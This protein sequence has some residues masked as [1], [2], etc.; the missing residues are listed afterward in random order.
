[1]TIRSTYQGSRPML[2]IA[3]DVGTTFS[4]AAYTI[5]R[6]GKPP[7]VYNVNGYKGQ[8]NKE[9]NS[10]V[11]SVLFYSPSGELLACGSEVRKLR[12][13]KGIKTEWFKLGLRPPSMAIKA[14][15][16]EM[17]YDRDVIGVFGDF[18]KYMYECV[19]TH[20]IDTHID[21]WSVWSSMSG[22]AHLVLSHPNGWGA[23]QQ[24]KMREAAIRG[25]LIPDTPE[26]RERIEFVTEG[27]ASFHWCIDKGL[28]GTS[29]QEGT[30]IVVADLGGGTIDVSSFIVTTR[31]PLRLKEQMAPDCALEGSIIV[32]KRFAD[33][34][35]R[36]LRGTPYGGNDY[37]ESLREEFDQEA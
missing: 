19:R 11:P 36:K 13:K 27:E 4:G 30:R 17:P 1:M 23:Y 35:R 2:V 29:L 22:T 34:E 10:K 33:Y 12:H 24:G 14:P 8:E 32:S 7:E 21:G 31:S 20:I 5:L 3:I 15:Q 6:A 37:I 16:V 18:L 9:G 28:A 26:G 25:G